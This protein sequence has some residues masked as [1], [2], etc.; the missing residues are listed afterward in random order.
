MEEKKFAV[1]F[2]TNSYRQLV[3]GLTTEDA[4]KNVEE[5]KAK[6]KK[7]NIKTFGI[8]VVGMEMLAHLADGEGAFNYKDCLNGVLAMGHHCFD[9]AQNAPLIVPQP[10]LHLTRA[11]FG[12]VP[13]EIEK[14]AKNMAGVV[15]DLRQ[16]LEK[17]L[18]FHVEKGTFKDIREYIHREEYDFSVQ[19]IDLIKGAELEVLNEHPKIDKKGLRKKLLEYIRSGSFEPYIAMSIITAIA[20]TLKRPLSK[21]E[22]TERACTMNL[23][24]PLSVGFYSWICYKILNESIDMGSKGSKEKRWNWLWDYQVSFLISPH[25]ID[26]REII[27]VTSDGDMTKMLKTFGYSNRVMNLYEYKAFLNT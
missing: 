10:Y 26:N 12:V 20:I 22:I 11:F 13:E 7:K 23:E 8:M 1:L 25:T 9:A 27:V 17:S 15:D 14:R 5:I 19:I 6:E 3:T 24:F 16:N 18:K 4:L 21:E 2:D